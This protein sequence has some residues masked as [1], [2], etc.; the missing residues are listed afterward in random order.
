MQEFMSHTTR[1]KQPFSNNY[2]YFFYSF[3]IQKIIKHDCFPVFFIF[4]INSY[5]Y[6]KRALKLALDHRLSKLRS[7]ANF[8]GYPNNRNEYKSF[9]LFKLYKQYLST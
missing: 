7:N 6:C 9:K 3:Y 2:K 8:I 4:K 1:L 5:F